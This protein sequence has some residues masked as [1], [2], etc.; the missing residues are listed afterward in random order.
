MT[1]FEAAINKSVEEGDI[2]LILPP[3]LET[4]F[5]MVCDKELA[6]GEQD[7]ILVE[8]QDEGQLCITVA[9]D[10]AHLEP[11]LEN[12]PDVVF[13][14]IK[15]DELLAIVRDEHEILVLF[16]EGGYYITRD[17][18]EW[19]YEELHEDEEG[20]DEESDEDDGEDE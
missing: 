14:E 2:D 17:Q 15:G 16:G 5:F 11:L 8:S 1:A 19:W 3:L 13:T 7:I 12:N 18:I 9:E 6:D 20:E 4:T 10:R